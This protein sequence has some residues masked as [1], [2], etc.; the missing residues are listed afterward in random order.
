MHYSK[1]SNS[2]VSMIQYIPHNIFENKSLSNLPTKSWM[3]TTDIMVSETS[4]V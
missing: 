3:D 4:Q 2:S 1:L